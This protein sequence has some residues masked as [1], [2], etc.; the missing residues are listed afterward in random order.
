MKGRK[1]WQIDKYKEKHDRIKKIFIEAT[2]AKRPTDIYSETGFSRVTILKHLRNLE[3]NGEIVKYAYGYVD[4][5]KYRMLIR[6]LKADA[7]LIEELDVG[8]QKLKSIIDQMMTPRNLQ[9]F[10][11]EIEVPFPKYYPEVTDLNAPARIDVMTD[12]QLKEYLEENK[13][14]F[15]YREKMLSALHRVFFDLT[16][17]LMTFDGPTVVEA[18]LS[19]VG[20]RFRNKKPEWMLLPSTS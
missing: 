19:D 8:V 2:G 15:K 9:R 7:G 5:D 20:V 1:Q 4:G 14:L 3:R 13:E 11:Q 17:I 12:E 6:G 18:D 16:K 10:R